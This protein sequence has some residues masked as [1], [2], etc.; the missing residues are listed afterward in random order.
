MIPSP[1]PTSSLLSFKQFLDFEIPTSSTRE[2][3]PSS[4]MKP[5]SVDQ[6]I[7]EHSASPTS[8]SSLQTTLTVILLTSNTI[9]FIHSK[10]LLSTYH[11]PRSVLDAGDISVNETDCDLIL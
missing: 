5:S 1:L 10:Y 4:S 3:L 9:S 8:I 2:D 7:A 11:V 6:K